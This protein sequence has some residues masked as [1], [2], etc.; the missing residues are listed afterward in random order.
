MGFFRDSVPLQYTPRKLRE[1]VVARAF[2]NSLVLEPEV[3]GDI[4]LVP[5]HRIGGMPINKP[6]R[7]Q[8]SFV[9][10]RK[11]SMNIF[12]ELFALVCIGDW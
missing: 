4:A 9:E 7:I 5:D 10:K 12:L 8:C 11:L 1:R 3:D 2:G 6:C